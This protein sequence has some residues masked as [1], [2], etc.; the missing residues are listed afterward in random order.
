MF[1]SVEL[2]FKRTFT[3]ENKAYGAIYFKQITMFIMFNM[4]T[5]RHVLPMVDTLNL[6]NKVYFVKLTAVII[7][8]QLC[9]L[10]FNGKFVMD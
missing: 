3:N 7:F 5:I 2:Q 10:F 8:M 1:R 9:R 4:S 6:L